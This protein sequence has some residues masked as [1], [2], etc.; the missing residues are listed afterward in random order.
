MLGLRTAYKLDLTCTTADMVYGTYLRLLGDCFC[1]SGT[2]PGLD[3]A[4]YS[5][6]LHNLL[7][8][9]YSCRFYVYVFIRHDSVKRPLQN[10]YDGPS[11]LPDGM[12]SILPSTPEEDVRTGY[13]LTPSNPLTPM[14][15]PPSV[16]ATLRFVTVSYRQL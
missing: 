9:I 10:L 13:Q 11:R 6:W 3:P 14:T 8:R 2:A 5:T 15:L 1:A 4:V 7:Q 16:C 12:P